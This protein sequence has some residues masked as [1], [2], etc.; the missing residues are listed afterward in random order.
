MDD[1]LSAMLT[2][3]KL[4]CSLFPN[5]HPPPNLELKRSQH[6]RTQ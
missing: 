2:G 1:I 3:K 6:E 5:T 4:G